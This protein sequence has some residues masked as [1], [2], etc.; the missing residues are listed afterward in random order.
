MKT[1]STQL[2][3]TGVAAA[4]L[5]ST[6]VFAQTDF[7]PGH[8]RVNE[9][10]NRLQDQ[11]ARTQAGVANGTITKKQARRDKRRDKRVARQAARDEAKQNGHLTKGEQVHMNHELNN[12]SNDI[13]TQR[14]Q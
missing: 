11:S 12:N 13:H 4:L 7:D 5:F 10:D 8:P 2:L 1:R 9:V 3:M 6:P 14:A